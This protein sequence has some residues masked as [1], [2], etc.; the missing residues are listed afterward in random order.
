MIKRV[1]VIDDDE[2]IRK[3]FLL[4]LE[5]TDLQVDTAISGAKGLEMMKQ[6]TYDLICLDLKMPELSGVDTLK[7]LRKIDPDILVYIITAYYGE[8]AEELRKAQ[9]DGLKFELM[10]KPL[11]SNQIMCLTKG[12]LTEAVVY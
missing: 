9:E 5:G 11:T 10:M 6:Q 4:A 2:A 8:F 1:L 3:V 7:K 12:I